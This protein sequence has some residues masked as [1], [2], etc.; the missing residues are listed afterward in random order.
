MSP[1]GVCLECVQTVERDDQS[2]QMLGEFDTEFV[3]NSGILS[4]IGEIVQLSVE[5]LES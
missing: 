5:A 2:R 3:P 1:A 4:P